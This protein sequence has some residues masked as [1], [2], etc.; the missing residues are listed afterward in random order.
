[1]RGSF[2]MRKDPREGLRKRLW[3][4]FPIGYYRLEVEASENNAGVR[5]SEYSSSGGKSRVGE[6]SEVEEREG[7]GN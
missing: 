3:S 1:M 6:L 7:S 5:V 4:M 2:N